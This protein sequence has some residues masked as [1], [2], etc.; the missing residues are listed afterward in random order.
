M[1]KPKLKLNSDVATFT[2]TLE[3]RIH[4][5]SVRTGKEVVE[6]DGKK[7]MVPRPQHLTNQQVVRDV[8]TFLEGRGSL[9]RCP[10]PYYF[11]RETK[12]L[13]PLVKDNPKLSQMLQEFGLLP[14]EIHTR[15][16]MKTL[17][18]KGAVAPMRETHRFSF[19]TRDA[20]Y[21]RRS[22]TEMYKIT[23]LSRITV[24]IGTDDVF[25]IAGDLTDLPTLDELRPQIDR[26]APV[27]GITTTG[28]IPGSPLHKLTSRW[29]RDGCLTPDQAHQMFFTRVM[30]L[31]AASMHRTW[32]LLL[33]TGDGESGKS[34]PIE[35]ILTFLL[36]KNGETQSMPGRMGDFVASVTNRTLQ[37][38]D[39]ID[40][41][42]LHRPANS[43][44][45]D[46]I[47]QLATGA[48]I[49]MREL[50]VTNSLVTY[51]IRGHG[52]FTARVNPFDHRPDLL[53]RTLHLPMEPADKRVK[54]QKDKLIGA[55]LKDRNAMFAEF[56]IRAQNIFKAH[57]ACE[58]SKEFA[59]VSQVVEYERFCY[60]AA[61]YEGSLPETMALWSAYMD[62]Y[63][64]TLTETNPLVYAVR[65]W[66]GKTDQ[67]G[68]LSNTNRQVSPTTLWGELRAV[69][70]ETQ[71]PFGWR[72]VNTMSRKI[73]E[74]K[75]P[76]KAIGCEE[77]RTRSGHAFI[78]RPS[79]QE[80]ATC[81]E[82]YRDA[83]AAALKNPSSSYVTRWAAEDADITTDTQVM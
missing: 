33:H 7:R 21:I 9:F 44:Y 35:L 49:D 28:L 41:A 16:V 69:S 52:M 66:L 64:R 57:Q 70:E 27:I 4:L 71:N 8:T 55:V 13:V 2:S 46:L 80:L 19:M 47:C 23:A 17:I 12:N 10:E 59:Y 45:S 36:G 83:L 38:Y 3:M 22:E 53:R 43:A 50:F 11:D 20:L 32:P 74:N 62:Q 42:G 1:A 77:I 75:T 39:N 61:E 78:F 60:I 14:D 34:T 24:S 40:D 56:L 31:V 72:T 5:N 26:L 79:P 29:L 6:I 67:S 76:L 68:T 37:A 63:D 73:N 25:L 81:R 54:I 15:I 58:D 82:M 51:R 65:L 18:A 48:E 30:F